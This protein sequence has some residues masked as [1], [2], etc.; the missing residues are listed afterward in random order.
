L[1][2]LDGLDEIAERSPRFVEDIV[3]GISS[4]LEQVLLAGAARP[5]FGI[6]ESFLSRG[7]LDRF[8]KGLSSMSENDARA[9]LLERAGNVRKRMLGMDKE[10]G[11]E[12]TNRFFAKVAERSDGLPIYLNCLLHDLHQGKISPESTDSLPRGIH[13]YH[14]ELLQ[15]QSIGDLQSVAT[16]SLVIL[17]MAHEPLTNL[18]LTMFLK[19]LNRIGTENLEL[20]DRVLQVLSSMLKSAP[21]PDGETGYTLY[22]HS[23]RDHIL[24]SLNIAETVT[25]IRKSFSLTTLRPSGDALD[26]YLYRRGVSHLLENNSGDDAIE[27]MTDFELTM[28]RFQALDLTGRAADSWYADWER[29]AKVTKFSGDCEIWW[30]FAKTNRHHFRKPGW[31]S[32]RVFFQAAMDHA[33]DSQVTIGAEKFYADGKCDWTWLRLTNRTKKIA[34]GHLIAV[35]VGHTDGVRG[36]QI[37]SHGRIL[38]W[39]SDGTLRLWDDKSGESLG[40]MIGHFGGVVGAKVL[41]DSR[42]ISWSNEKNLR[43]WDAKRGEPIGVLKGHTNCVNGARILEDDRILSW[44]EDGTLRLWD[45]ENG[46]PVGVMEGHTASVEGSQLLPDGRILSWSEDGTLRLWNVENGEP[47]GV[48]EGHTDG[49]RGAQILSDGRILSW[50]SDTTLRFWDG[51]SGEALGILEGHDQAVFD[52][53]ELIDGSIM[54]ISFDFTIRIWDRENG[55]EIGKLDNFA[56]DGPMVGAAELGANR[57]VSWSLAGDRF[58]LWWKKDGGWGGPYEWGSEVYRAQKLSDE[59]ILSSTKEGILRI[60]NTSKNFGESLCEMI[61]HT[62]SVN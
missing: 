57:I 25:S 15:R 42:I 38:S 4:D 21:D 48:L 54:S 43:L 2:L 31:E 13:A 3:F 11:E 24:N 37:L 53:Q 46:E 17:A 12:V 49:V 14:E 39:S 34:P 30:E 44:S 32:W 5:E 35:L 20:T 7:A 52:V 27:W 22:H 10:K 6:P 23:L 41:K 19:R 59:C 50:S 58:A 55:A 60:W 61:G 18:E 47:V 62:N 28:A 51:E 56:G 29:L 16:P 8:P 9:F 1:L 26:V 40:V 33:D 36:A 45:G